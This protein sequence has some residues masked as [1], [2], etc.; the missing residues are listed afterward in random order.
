MNT[1]LLD[2]NYKISFLL[3]TYPCDNNDVLGDRSQ[4]QLQSLKYNVRYI[5]KMRYSCIKQTFN[6]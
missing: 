5:L 3:I 1:L 2:I 4:Q 6:F